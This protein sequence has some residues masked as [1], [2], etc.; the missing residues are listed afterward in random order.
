[1]TFSLPSGGEELLT[2]PYAYSPKLKE[3]VVQILEQNAER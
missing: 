2:A 3:K 1:M